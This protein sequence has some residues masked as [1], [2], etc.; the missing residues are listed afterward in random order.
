MVWACVVKR[1]P[2]L[3]EEMYG[4][5]SGPLFETKWVSWYQKK[6]SPTH[7]Y[8]NHQSSFISYL[9]LLRSIASFLFNLRAWQSFC[10]AALQVLIGLRLGMAHCTSCSIHFFIQA[11]SSFRN[12]CPY[13]RKLFCCSTDIMSCDPSLSLAI[14]LTILISATEVSSHFLFWLKYFNAKFCCVCVHLVLNEDWRTNF[15]DIQQQNTESQL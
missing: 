12:T 7:T 10:T 14:H 5:W 4:V 1:K 6:H 15:S 3:G 11:L 2:C 13:H 8:P 9:N